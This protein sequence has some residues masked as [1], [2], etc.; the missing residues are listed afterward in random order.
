MK[1]F[2]R[3]LILLIFILSIDG[4]HIKTKSKLILTMPP[5]TIL[6]STANYGTCLTGK[7]YSE[8]EPVLNSWLF[9]F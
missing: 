7:Y 3:F 2:L 5:N 8:R 4:V 9:F 1:K 6:P